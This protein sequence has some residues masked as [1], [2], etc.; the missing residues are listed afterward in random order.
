MCPL[1]ALN[2]ILAKLS[3]TLKSINNCVFSL[4]L[5]LALTF[6]EVTPGQL[7]PLQWPV[8]CVSVH[9]GLDCGS[10]WFGGALVQQEAAEPSLGCA[11]APWALQVMDGASGRCL[12]VEKYCSWA[13]L[14]AGVC[15]EVSSVWGV[16][17]L[18]SCRHCSCTH[19]SSQHAL[20]LLVLQSY[21][22]LRCRLR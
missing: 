12:M 4:R 15:C 2:Y 19:L 11:M 16:W 10:V 17:W 3:Q 5:G 14:R 18:W 13:Q 1:R 6:L 22:G 8:Q 20:L 7:C 9:V 21:L